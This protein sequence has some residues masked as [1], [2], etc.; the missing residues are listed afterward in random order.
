MQGETTMSHQ[1]LSTSLISARRSANTC[2]YI[3]RP[4]G[5]AQPICFGAPSPRAN[6]LFLSQL[7]RFLHP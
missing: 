3:G 1:P 7:S 2:P 6:A 4:F 5:K